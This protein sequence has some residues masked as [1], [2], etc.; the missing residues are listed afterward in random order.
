[1]RATSLVNVTS[2]AGAPGVGACDADTAM[3]RKN[4][5]AIQNLRFAI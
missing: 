5:A 4:G 1:M 2:P 3:P